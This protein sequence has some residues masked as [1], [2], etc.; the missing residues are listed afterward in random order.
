MITNRLAVLVV[1]ALFACA[2]PWS[3]PGADQLAYMTDQSRCSAEAVRE[4]PRTDLWREIPCNADGSYLNCATRSARSTVAVPPAP[5]PREQQ[6][7]E[8]NLRDEAFGTCM[9]AAGW[10]RGAGGP[11][12]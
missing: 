6:E 5:V 10:T 11:K 7:R 4:V 2:A 8:R 3:K 12:T 1:P 9:E